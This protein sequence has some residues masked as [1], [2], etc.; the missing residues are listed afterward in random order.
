MEETFGLESLSDFTGDKEIACDILN[1]NLDVMTNKGS[2]I[3]IVGGLESG[4]E[5]ELIASLNEDGKR[6]FVYG[7]NLKNDKVTIEALESVE[8]LVIGLKLNQTK[9]EEIQNHLVR[10]YNLNKPVL[11]YILI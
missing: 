3:M 9:A 2:S 10:A 7:D 4:S 6:S 8:G 11:G 1:A 5:D